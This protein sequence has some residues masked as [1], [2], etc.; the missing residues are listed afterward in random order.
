MRSRK[1]DMNEL[2]DDENTSITESGDDVQLLR[3]KQKPKKLDTKEFIQRIKKLPV[4]TASASCAMLVFGTLF[5]IF[6]IYCAFVCV[7]KARMIG[8]FV[9]GGILFIPGT[10]S[11]YIL[12]N[13]VKGSEGFSLDDLPSYDSD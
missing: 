10:Y 8:W 3:S 2:S 12:Y 6:G 5:I 7:E 4:K 13:V 9:V 11:V 1:F